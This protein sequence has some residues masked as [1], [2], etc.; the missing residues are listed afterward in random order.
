MTN[1][2]WAAFPLIR[3]SDLCQAAAIQST[4]RSPIMI[5]VA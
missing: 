2:L 1:L 3:E 5:T 4:T